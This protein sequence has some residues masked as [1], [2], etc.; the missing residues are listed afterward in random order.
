MQRMS[1]TAGRPVRCAIY[2]RKSVANGLDLE[3]NSLEVQREIC[4][5]YIRS[6]RHRHWVE[7]PDRF[8]DGGYTGG[9]LNRPNLKRLLGAVEQGLVDVIVVYKLDRLTRSLSDFIRLVDL[10]GQYEVTFVSV[11]QAFDTQD[12]LGRLVLN[13]LLTF[14]QFEREMLADR[15]R[16]KAHALRRAGRWIGGAAPYGYD[17][18]DKRLIRN[19]GEAATVRLIHERYLE[20]RSANQVTREME[21]QGMR[22]KAW[23]TRGGTSSGGLRVTQS[24]VYGILGNPIYIGEFHVEG[25]VIKALHEPIVDRQVWSEV[26]DLKAARRLKKPANPPHAH[27]LLGLVFDEFNRK[28]VISA[29][30]KQGT[31]YRYY[32]STQNHRLTK[33]GTKALRAGAADLED[34]VRATVCAFFRDRGRVS[35]AVHA[36]G[37]RDMDTDR[38][39]DR[40]AQAARWLETFDRRRLRKAWEALIERIEISRE[41]VIVIV[42][43][44]QVRALLAWPGSGLFKLKANGDS[45]HH[46]VV[47]LEAESFAVRTE[48]QFRLPLNVSAERRSPKRGLVDLLTFARQVQAIVYEER[49]S[50]EEIARRFSR[51]P[52]FI[53]RALRLNYLAPD[54]LSAIV[55]GRQPPD[56]TRRKLLNS[57]IPTDWAQ[58]RAL[59]GFATQHD[60][61]PNDEHF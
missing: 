41:R 33:T 3:L 57:S 49:Q 56:L 48:R 44:E 1:P 13:I 35:A 61:R 16:D 6:Q 50:V 39:I 19:E 9:N 27:L 26:S 59:F 45:R 8:D 52:T 29:G 11:T 22:S 24:L 5:A 31:A 47:L 43:C 46:H 36:L 17:L 55:D 37:Y 7:L 34:L 18:I 30:V 54:I 38:L 32:A 40:G 21:A 4:S 14:A 51:R 2:T 20:L 60:P 25:E 53:T 42:R 15:I 58:Q 10:L 28:M 23:I 12:S